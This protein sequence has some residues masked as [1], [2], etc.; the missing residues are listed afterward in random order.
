MFS[1][2]VS[3]ATSCTQ[4]R[5]VWLVGLESPTPLG[6]EIAGA[7]LSISVRPQRQFAHAGSSFSLLRTLLQANFAWSD[8]RA[9]AS[10]ATGKAKSE[11]EVSQKRSTTPLARDDGA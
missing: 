3:R 4:S 7:R 1:G 5:T 6:G 8:W 9:S 10:D 2:S 11:E